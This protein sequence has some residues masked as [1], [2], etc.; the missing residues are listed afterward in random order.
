MLI[1]GD[2]SKGEFIITNRRLV[3]ANISQQ[4]SIFHRENI[5]DLWEIGIWEILDIELLDVKN[6]NYPFIR[7]RYKEDETYFTFPDYEPRPTLAALIIFINHARVFLKTQ[8]LLRS[9]G[10]NLAKNKL[11]VGERLPNL[12]IDQPLRSDQTCHQCAKEMLT[13]D[14]EQIATEIEECIYCDFDT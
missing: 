4:K 9:I 10:R 2:I 5:T 12:V 3:F 11:E 14:T 8:S 6:F 1:G 7:F 13:N